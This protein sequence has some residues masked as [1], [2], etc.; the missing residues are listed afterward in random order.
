MFIETSIECSERLLKK[1]YEHLSKN[2]HNDTHLVFLVILFELFS[3]H[4]YMFPELTYFISKSLSLVGGLA[5]SGLPGDVATSNN[6]GK[7]HPSGFHPTEK[8]DQ[9][10]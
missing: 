9:I 1:C 3:Y 5:C 2:I 6:V 10:A 8:T 4:E 7:S